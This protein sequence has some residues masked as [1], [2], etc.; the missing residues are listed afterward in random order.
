VHEHKRGLVLGRVKAGKP[1][2][3]RFHGGMLVKSVWNDVSRNGPEMKD[4][5]KDRNK[6]PRSFLL[7]KIVLFFFGICRGPFTRLGLGVLEQVESRT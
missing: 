1:Q 4:L 2:Q 5:R 3:D 6:I 7:S